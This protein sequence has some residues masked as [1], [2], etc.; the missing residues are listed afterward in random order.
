MR[1]SSKSG[2]TDL[3]LSTVLSSGIGIVDL[4]I[5]KN[6]IIELLIEER[7][8]QLEVQLEEA[9]AASA[10]ARRAALQEIVAICQE[11]HDKAVN[12]YKAVI[13]AF[14]AAIP[15][16]KIST[17]NFGEE[18]ES[19][20][21]A[22]RD[23]KRRKEHYEKLQRTLRDNKYEMF[24]R[25]CN[26]QVRCPAEWNSVQRSGELDVVAVFSEKEVNAAQVRAEKAYQAFDAVEEQVEALQQERR[27]LDKRGTRIKVEITQRML[28]ASKEGQGVIAMLESIRESMKSSNPFIISKDS[29]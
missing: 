19:I 27:D 16:A 25:V 29:K 18:A 21:R 2:C 20:L 28:A 6:E 10:A 24:S 26:V 23:N 22:F 1:K 13:E 3:N 12:Q 14:V 17:R 15:A 9:N 11:R 5:T 7:R 8:S 4:K